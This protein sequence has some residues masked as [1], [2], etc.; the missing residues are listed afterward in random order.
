M[1]PCIYRGSPIGEL[2]VC[3]NHHDLIHDG[4]VPIDVCEYC[5]YATEERKPRGDFF[6][7]TADLLLHKARTGEYVANPKP[8]GGCNEVKRRETDVMQ[9]VFPYWHFGASDDEIR[10]AVR[11]IEQ[12]YQGKSKITIIGDK[13]PWYSGHYIPQQRV[14]KHTANRPFRDMLSKVWTMATHPEIDQEFVWMMDDIYFIKPVTFEALAVPRA[15]RWQES[16]SNSWQRRKK[17]TMRAL[18]ATGRTVHDYATHLPHVVEKDKLQQLYDEFGLQRNTMLWEVLYGNTFRSNPQSPFPFFL[19]I[20]KKIGLEDLKQLTEQASVFNH[21]SSAWCPGVREF[22]AELLKDPS[23]CESEH[24]FMPKYK[25][26]QRVRPPVKRRPPETHRVHVESVARQQ[27]AFEHRTRRADSEGGRV[28]FLSA[29]MIKELGV[30]KFYE[31]SP[32]Q[33]QIIRELCPD[34][35]IVHVTKG[36]R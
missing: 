34:C 17:N 6:S 31:D 10:W 28:G 20:Q 23:S 35:E 21:T 7:Q 12:N 3:T 18:A 26:T 15:V 33:I 25:V 27:A 5:P 30:T 36:T 2:I 9:F 16:E 11:S 8:C 19:R 4:L 14:H 22:L 29:A 13:P 24:T 1:K 32:T